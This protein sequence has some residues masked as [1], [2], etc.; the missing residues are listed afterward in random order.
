MDLKDVTKDLIGQTDYRIEQ[1]MQQM[2]R[3]NPNFKNLDSKNKELVFD[4]IKKYK[5]KMR[6]GIKP[7][8]YTIHQD[9]YNLYENRIKLNL[10]PHDLEQIR[11]LLGSFKG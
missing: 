10:T 6:Q 11:D 5:E 1:R 3:T 8:A 2:F 4:L 9:T 7:S